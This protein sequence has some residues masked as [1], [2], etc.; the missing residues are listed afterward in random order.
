VFPTASD[1]D[2]TTVFVGPIG[3]ETLDTSGFRIRSGLDFSGAT[4]VYSGFIMER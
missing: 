4:R 3:S 2:V 1:E